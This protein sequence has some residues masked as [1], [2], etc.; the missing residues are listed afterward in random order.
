MDKKKVL[1][2]VH[3]K[4]KC[5]IDV[6]KNINISDVTP[7]FWVVLRN[8]RYTLYKILPNKVDPLVSLIMVKKVPDSTYEMIALQSALGIAQPK[9]VL[10]G[11]HCWP[12]LWLIIGTIPLFMTLALNWDRNSLGNFCHDRE[13]AHLS[14]S[15]MKLT[16]SAP[17]MEGIAS[18]EGTVKCSR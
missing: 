5:V 16:P 11:R 10:L 18:L 3:P 2:Q 6:D 1:V 14:S 9:G 12:G 13:N 4:D 17:R 7:S 15:W 8:D